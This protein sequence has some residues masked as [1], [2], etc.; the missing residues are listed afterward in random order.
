VG[1]ELDGTPLTFVPKGAGRAARL[2]LSVVATHRDSG[3]AERH[4]DVVEI[5]VPEGEDPGWRAVTREFE[6]PPGIVQVRVV[7]R[8]LGGGSMG[9]VTQRIEVPLPGGLHVSTPV[10]TDRLEPAAETMGRP[11]PALAVH[12]TF[13][14]QGHLFCQYEVFGAVSPGDGAP[15]R[16]RAGFSLRNA[17]GDGRVLQQAGSTPIAADADGRLVR[18]VGVGLDGLPEGD[19]EVVLEVHDE[20]SGQKTERIE[21]FTLS[22][23][24]I[25][26]A[27]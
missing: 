22:R 20:V 1:V 2:V 6:L 14:P 27:P 19:Y 7:A 4:D 11:R 23:P 21:P 15:P 8:D 25:A 24:R 3:R 9:A 5:A 18:M 12:R 17:S 26:S 13:A 10:L 16:V